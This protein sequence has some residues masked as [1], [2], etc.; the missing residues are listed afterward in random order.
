MATRLLRFPILPDGGGLGPVEVVYEFDESNMF[1]GFAL[2]SEGGAWITTLVSNRLW[3]VSPQGRPHLVIE[4]CNPEQVAR[5]AR[6][7]ATTGV[8]ISILYEERRQ[9]LCN[10]ASVA[11]G[12]PDLRT[13][14]LGSLTGESIFHFPSPVP[15]M[16]PRHWDYRFNA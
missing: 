5:L 12:G 15:G 11:F 16:K 2:D 4:D 3:Y 8:P 6:Y 1:D 7:Q 10:I 14:Y 9:T 13:I